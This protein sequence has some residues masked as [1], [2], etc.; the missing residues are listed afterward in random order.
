MIATDI[1]GT[2]DLL[3]PDVGLLYPVGD[4]PGLAARI[5]RLLQHPSLADRL[6]VAG[7]GKVAQHE[8]GRVLQLHEEL[9]ARALAAR[10]GEA[11]GGT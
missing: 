3:A 5:R 9:Y 10:T 4:V 2:K 11:R 1:R 6:V 8:L 7:R